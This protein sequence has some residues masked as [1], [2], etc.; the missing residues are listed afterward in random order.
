M[1]IVSIGDNLHEMPKP[2]FWEN[3]LPRFYKA[4]NSIALVLVIF[5]GK[6]VSWNFFLEKFTPLHKMQM[7]ALL[8]KNVCHSISLHFTPLHFNA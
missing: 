5:S 7:V 8:E 4:Y 6:T 3:F 1:Q 2:V